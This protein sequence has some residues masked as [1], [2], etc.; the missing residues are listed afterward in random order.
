MAD[1]TEEIRR[2]SAKLAEYKQLYFIQKQ[3]RENAGQQFT[4]LQD[5]IDANEQVFHTAS[6]LINVRSRSPGHKLFQNFFFSADDQRRQRRQN[7]NGKIAVYNVIIMII[8]RFTSY[9][10]TQ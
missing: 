8:L 2:L 5:E 3:E 9:G 7:R 4:Q 10:I 1:L 6:Y